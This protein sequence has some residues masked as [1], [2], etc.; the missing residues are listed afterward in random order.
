MENVV[1]P[2]NK[3]V[4]PIENNVPNEKSLPLQQA[5]PPTAEIIEKSEQTSADKPHV[6]SPLLRRHS[7]KITMSVAAVIGVA[8]GARLILAGDL[9][10]E[11]A[12]N[13][14]A[15]TL[16]GSFGEIFLRQAVLGTVFLCVEFLLGFFAFGDILVWTVPF[17]ST[18]GTVLRLFSAGSPKILPGTLICLV[19]VVAGAAYSADM[20]E[21]LMRLSRGGTVYMETRP[22][23][24]YA[25][26]FFGCLAGVVFGAILVGALALV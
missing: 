23:R 14:V 21:L 6:R 19:A 9:F 1:K 16:V 10:A 11:N 26:H 12:A 4:L 8:A 22:K 24:T 2:H 20:S 17:L 25:L 13:A 7:T 3:G 15:Q 18:V 5:A